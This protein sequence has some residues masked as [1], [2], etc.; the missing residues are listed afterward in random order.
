MGHDTMMC[1]NGPPRY[2]RFVVIVY[3]GAVVKI[4]IANIICPN[5]IAGGYLKS[6]IV[7]SASTVIVIGT[8]VSGS[9]HGNGVVIGRS[10]R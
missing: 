8:I 5:I 1:A 9:V 3:V 10:E 2:Y 6:A 7:D 4:Q